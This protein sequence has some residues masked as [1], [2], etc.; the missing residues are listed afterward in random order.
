MDYLEHVMKAWEIKAGQLS[1]G[2]K[3]Y[4]RAVEIFND[5]LDRDFKLETDENTYEKR[6]FLN[7]EDKNNLRLACKPFFEK[8]K[9]DDTVY[10]FPDSSDSIMITTDKNKIKAIK[11]TVEKD[12][13]ESVEPEKA[14]VD[15]YKTTFDRTLKEAFN[16]LGFDAEIMG[17][18]SKSLLLLTANMGLKTYRVNVDGKA[19]ELKM[20]RNEHID[21]DYLKEQRKNNNADFTLIVGPSFSSEDIEKKAA[22]ENFSILRVEELLKLIKQ[23]AKFPFTLTQ[24]KKLFKNKGDI[25]EPL[26]KLIKENRERK[27]LLKNI[28]NILGEMYKI[29]NEKGYFTYKKLKN[30]DE[31]KELHISKKDFEYI[32]KLL[33]IPFVNGIK[34]IKNKGYVLTLRKENVAE[35]FSHI[36]GKLNGYGK[37]EELNEVARKKMGKKTMDKPATEY[38]RWKING[39]SVIAFKGN[40]VESQDTC[41]V[42][43]FKNIIKKIILSFNDY[44]V[45]DSDIIYSF[46]RDEKLGNNRPFRWQDDKYKIRMTLG[47]LELERI[48]KWTGATMPVQYKLNVPLKELVEWTRKTIFSKS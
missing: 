25:T 2:K 23:H 42:E 46:L 14:K 40:N 27:I 6:H 26:N 29:Q 30:R 34:K 4:S 38:H 33:Q 48:I 36:S 24:M 11:K 37:T 35:I 12:I 21:W 22:S 47:I 45:V 16:F 3:K 17:Y 18:T 8:L 9:K 39:E 41:P 15:V 20:V 5:Y 1:I 43:H 19:L 13:K 32:V 10:L 7:Y 44:N 28:K 31:I